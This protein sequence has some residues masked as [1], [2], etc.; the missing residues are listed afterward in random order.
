MTRRRK[1]A[2]LGPVCCL[3]ALLTTAPAAA[4]PP[5]Q[6]CG[7]PRN[8]LLTVD[9]N[10]V[11]GFGVMQTRATAFIFADGAVVYSAVSTSGFRTTPAQ[12]SMPRSSA[13][14]RGTAA[15]DAFASLVSALAAAQVGH[16]HDCFNTVNDVGDFTD[17]R[18]TWHG[19]GSRKNTFLVSTN[20][21][22]PDCG[23][24]IDDLIRRIEGTLGSALSSPAAETLVSGPF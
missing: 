14:A 11:S 18:L 21:T 6:F 12:G 19:K 22:A 20:V 10:H 13:V 24:E 2:A 16:A 15:Q 5:V 3:V 1:G 9:S 8:P 7:M 17:F 23:P 4:A